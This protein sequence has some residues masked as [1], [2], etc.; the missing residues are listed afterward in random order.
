MTTARRSTRRWRRPS[1]RKATALTSA[2]RMTCGRTPLRSCIESLGAGGSTEH[3]QVLPTA[4]RIGGRSPS[5]W[6]RTGSTRSS[7]STSIPAQLTLLDA[8]DRVRLS[9]G[10]G[11]PLDLELR[12]AVPPWALSLV[13]GGDDWSWSWGDAP[14][15]MLGGAR[16]P[17]PTSGPGRGAGTGSRASAGSTA[18]AGAGGKSR[19]LDG[20]AM[21]RESRE[22]DDG[23]GTG[24]P[25]E[26]T[27]EAGGR[28]TT[29]AADRQLDLASAR[30][31]GARALSSRPAL[32]AGR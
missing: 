30:S 20:A 1:R 4:K 23:A 22:W 27:D 14:F 10:R 13:V 28:L 25:A 16:R 9:S 32:Y 8:F 26:P 17:R 31:T 21:R 18:G 24:Q 19:A 12:R 15:G 11:N 2:A 6:S 5:S 3:G 7:S 29:L